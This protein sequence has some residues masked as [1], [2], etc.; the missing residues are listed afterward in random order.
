VECVDLC[1]DFKEPAAAAAAAFSAARRLRASSQRPSIAGRLKRRHSLAIAG[2]AGT[3]GTARLARL[4]RLAGIAA[5][6]VA[7]VAAAVALAQGAPTPSA[8]V[9][10]PGVLPAEPAPLAQK[11]LLLDLAHAGSRFVAV[12]ERG[13]VL[14]SD[15]RG[16]SWSQSAAVPS[17]EMLT[18]VCFSDEK[19]GVAVG[20]DEIALVTAD[21]GNTWQRTHY[22]P[23]ARQPL[24]DVLCNGSDVIAVGAYGAYFTSNDRGATWA[25]R[26]FE[27]QP[28]AAAKPKSEDRYADDGI[29]GDFHLNRIVGASGSRLYIAA[30]AGHLYRSDDAGNT[31]KE[32][33]SPYEGSF[34]GILPLD[35]DSLL[36]YGLRGHLYRSDD[37][38]QNWRKI[39]VGADA[40]LND[41]RRL[42]QNGVAI[43][44]LSGTVLVS[45]DGGETFVLHQQA[46]R[47]G[48]SAVLAVGVTELVTVGEGGV[49]SI[50]VEAGK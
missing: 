43:V 8:P 37:G 38:G 15:N 20:H 45:K 36:A 40:M 34:F 26:K 3:A 4:A 48:L 19:H 24:L 49:K 9:I 25:E 23:D 14:T 30:E 22:A 11:S 1:A 21:A 7:V 31:W 17:Q 16:Q 5:G 50:P 33:P 29:G 32:L 39:E 41:A 10:D 27:A 6:A 2:T 44:G 12:G 42:P 46:D 35:G 47:R 18:A 13:H 28:V